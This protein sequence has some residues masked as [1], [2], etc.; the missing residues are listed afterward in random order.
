MRLNSCA[1]D[2]GVVLLVAPAERWASDKV[3]RVVVRS[4]LGL[5]VTPSRGLWQCYGACRVPTFSPCRHAGL[6][7]AFTLLAA[8]T[9]TAAAA[10][11]GA[12]ALAVL[13]APCGPFARSLLAHSCSPVFVLGCCV[14]ALR[15]CV[16][17]MSHVMSPI[18]LSLLSGPSG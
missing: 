6:G 16:V 10:G 8:A 15:R 18:A 5:M 13:S 7:E 17:F 9:R 14:V 12:G 11:F 3:S 4:T 1:R 2:V